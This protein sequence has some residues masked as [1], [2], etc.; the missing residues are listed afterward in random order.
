MLRYFRRK[1]PITQ[2]TREQITDLIIASAWDLTPTQWEGLSDFDR[3]EC[4]RLVVTAP[5]FVA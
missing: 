3:A 4:R 2:L 1:R 5:R